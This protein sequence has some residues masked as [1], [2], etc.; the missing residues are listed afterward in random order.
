MVDFDAV[1]DL[2]RT[3]SEEQYASALESWDFALRAATEPL[4][5]K[6]TSAFGSVFFASPSGAIWL[7]DILDGSLTRRWSDREALDSELASAEGPDSVLM[8]TFVQMAE[9]AGIVPGA[10]QILDF[11]VAP[12]LGGSFDVANIQC[13]D[14]VV[15]VNIAGQLHR[16]LLDKPAGWR[17]DRVVLAD[18]PQPK[19]RGL[20]RRGN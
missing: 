3:W 19:R 9:R 6:F 5:A 12:A 14:F 1:P 10:N 2:T 11:T 8:S 16:Q 20:F 17:P 4:Q 13:I 15:G 7:L 18:T